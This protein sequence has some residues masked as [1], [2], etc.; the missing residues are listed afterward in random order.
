MNVFALSSLPVTEHS[1]AK[2]KHV[3][4]HP[5]N[6]CFAGILQPLEQY[7]SQVTRLISKSFNGHQFTKVSQVLNSEAMPIWI[8]TLILCKLLIIPNDQVT[9]MQYVP[10]SP[11]LLDETAQNMAAAKFRL[12]CADY[13]GCEGHLTGILPLFFIFKLFSMEIENF[14]KTRGK[15]PVEIRQNFSI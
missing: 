13:N 1:M 7:P 8:N 4:M 6:G 10:Q 2:G 14:D 3:F 12:Q 9:I 11:T 15:F 5:R